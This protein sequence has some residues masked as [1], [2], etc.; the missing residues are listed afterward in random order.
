E[1]GRTG[2]LVPCNDPNELAHAILTA[3][4]KPEVAQRKIEAVRQTVSKF[5]HRQRLRILAHLYETL[6]R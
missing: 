6:I 5:R 4:F 1:K 2:L 3:L